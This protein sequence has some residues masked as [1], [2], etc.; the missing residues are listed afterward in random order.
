MGKVP[1]WMRWPRLRVRWLSAVWGPRI[2]LL[3]VPYHLLL[4][5]GSEGCGVRS[6][7]GRISSSSS[8][9]RRN[10]RV[11]RQTKNTPWSAYS[12]SFCPGLTLFFHVTRR[13]RC[14]ISGSNLSWR[15]T[16]CGGRRSPLSINQCWECI[17]EVGDEI[18]SLYTSDKIDALPRC[19]QQWQFFFFFDQVC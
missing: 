9:G 8:S 11:A 13:G 2:P 5:L 14:F 18:V 3:S 12:D 6:W 7:T 19:H 1:G 15:A 4:S 17:R 10:L 16:Y